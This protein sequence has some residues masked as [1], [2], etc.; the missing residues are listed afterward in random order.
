M[1]ALVEALKSEI[2]ADDLPAL[3]LHGDSRLDNLMFVPGTER[4]A[5]VLDWEL[6]TFGHALADLGQFLAVQALP[7]DCLLP[8]LGG[9]DREAAGIPTVDAQIGRYFEAIGITPCSLRLYQ[10]FAMFRQAAMSAG[11][12][13]RAEQGTAV[14]ETALAFGNTMTV[15]A[16][17]GLDL[18]DGRNPL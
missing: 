5:A 1:D 18:L 7:S 3:L 6:S 17:V 9:I 12:K 16:R 11:L 2:P 14:N 13:R 8:G 10:G 4:V 15:F